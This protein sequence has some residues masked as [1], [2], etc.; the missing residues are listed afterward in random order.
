MIAA[1]PRAF[2]LIELLVVI[3][4]IALLVG[5]LLPALAKAQ[6]AA[7]DFQCITRAKEFF[8]DLQ[9]GVYGP[10]NDIGTSIWDGSYYYSPTLWLN[11]NRYQTSLMTPV[12]T[13]AGAGGLGYWRRNRIDDVTF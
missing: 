12:G 9:N 4:I 7:N 8:H 2:T 10:G 3:A 1:K 6:I 13:T 11:A 5:I